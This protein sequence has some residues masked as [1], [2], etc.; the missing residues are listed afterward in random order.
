MFVRFSATSARP[1]KSA[2][3]VEPILEAGEECHEPGTLHFF[4]LVT[5]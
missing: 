5:G 4:E 3:R 2:A 1:A